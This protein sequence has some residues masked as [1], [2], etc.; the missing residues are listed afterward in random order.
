MRRAMQVL[1]AVA[2]LTVLPFLPAGPVAAASAEAGPSPPATLILF[3]GEGCPHCAA[4][5]EF[6]AGLSEQYP[7]LLIQQ[8]EVWNDAGNLAFLESTAARMGFE[9]SGVPVTV[10]DER[11]WIG[12]SNSIAEEITAAVAVAVEAA[13]PSAPAAT[14]GPLVSDTAADQPS[15]TV[16]LP[17]LGS[18]DVATSSLVVATLAIGFV[19]GVNPC[20][21]WVL[22]LL[23]A[24]VLSRGSRGR[25]VLVGSTFLAVTAAMYGLYIVG[26]YSALDYV[27]SLAWIQVV[28]AVVALAFGALQ[29]K[30]GIRPGS[31]PSLSIA[32][33]ARPRIYGRMRA[34]A[35]PGSGLA[36]TLA[37]T[38]ALAIG[39]SLLET[40]C[41]A[42]LPL[43]WTS[44]LAQQGVSTMTAV[45]LF[46]LYMGAFLLDELLVFGF[47]VVTL[48]GARLQERQGRLL[49]IVAGSLLVTLGLTMLVAPAA[50]ETLAGTAIVFAV[51][52][53]AAGGVWL[54]TQRSRRPIQRT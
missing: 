38:V 13:G 16:D 49:K 9:A 34:V 51:A 42:G 25:V 3:H 12:F 30:D 31:G 43:M 24:M 40:P 36:A 28:V 41:T 10:I 52:A 18:V 11:V 4:E 47:A 53:I 33:S 14:P 37:G 1:L 2:A 39:V 54:A 45:A 7:E 48:R 5:R 35:A 17:L 44:M 27:G 46:A 21:L 29:L 26:F 8:Y 6:L 20:S 19:D 15:A 32:E 22:S 50:L 23:L